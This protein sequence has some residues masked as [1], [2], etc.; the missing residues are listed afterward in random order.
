MSNAQLAD[1]LG[2]AEFEV[3]S[4]EHRR[5]LAR[6]FVDSHIDYEPEKIRWP[7]LG[8]TERTRLINLPFWQEAV[9]TESYTSATVMAAAQLEPDTELRRAIELQGL[10]ENRHARLLAAL[11]AH[12]RIP[13]ETPPT[14]PAALAGRRFPVRRFRRMFRFLLCLRADCRGGRVGLFHPRVGSDL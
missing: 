12:Y 9:S 6:F 11:T 3:G 2:G 1:N 13:I 4:A 14:L 10:E 7:T 5:G 8:E